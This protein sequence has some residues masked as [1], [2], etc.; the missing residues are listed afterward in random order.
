ML[1]EEERDTCSKFSKI[2]RQVEEGAGSKREKEG[3][4]L[5]EAVLFKK[6]KK[7]K[8]I[9]EICHKAPVKAPYHWSPR[10]VS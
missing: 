5:I 8:N 3:E 6:K 1:V 10:K 2:N 9:Q 7:T 4:D